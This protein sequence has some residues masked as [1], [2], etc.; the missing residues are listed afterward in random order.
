KPLYSAEILRLLDLLAAPLRLQ[1]EKTY[2]APL[3]AHLYAKET[4]TTPD[5]NQIRDFARLVYGGAHLQYPETELVRDVLWR[6][7]YGAG[8]GL[9]IW[10]G[11]IA[12]L[13]GVKARQ[14]RISFFRMQTAIWR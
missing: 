2:S 4:I 12:S 8:A 1:T 13:S 11:L 6:S 3:S 9:L 14:Y 7:A 10:I 5:G